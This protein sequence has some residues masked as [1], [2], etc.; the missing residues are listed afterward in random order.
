MK[1]FN[2]TIPLESSNFVA[3][4]AFIASY[5]DLENSSTINLIRETYKDKMIVYGIHNHVTNPAN[6]SWRT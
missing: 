6:Y 2:H 4:P 5:S 3:L 1:E